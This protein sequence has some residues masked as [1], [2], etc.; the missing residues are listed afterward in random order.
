MSEVDKRRYDGRRVPSHIWLGVSVETGT[1]RSLIE[2]LRQINSEGLFFMSIEPYRNSND[3]T[4]C[5]IT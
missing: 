4:S 3:L 1:H 2:H 5:D